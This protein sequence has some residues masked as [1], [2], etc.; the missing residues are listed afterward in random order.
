MK[1]NSNTLDE[2]VLKI[3]KILNKKKP[4][5]SIFHIKRAFDEWKRTSPLAKSI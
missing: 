3:K 1:R 4:K 5:S 2:M